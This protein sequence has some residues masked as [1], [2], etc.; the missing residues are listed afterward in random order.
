MIEIAIFPDEIVYAASIF[1]GYGLLCNDIPGYILVI[2]LSSGFRRTRTLF[3][4]NCF[5]FGY[6]FI[7]IHLDIIWNAQLLA[8]KYMD[9]NEHDR[10][11]SCTLGHK[12]KQNKGTAPLLLFYISVTQ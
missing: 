3:T 12:L 2:F 5:Y 11:S 6:A 7:V 4:H 9:V 1:S 10:L 8:R